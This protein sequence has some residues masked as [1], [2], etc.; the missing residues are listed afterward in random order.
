MNFPEKLKRKITIRE[1]DNALRHLGEMNDLVDF[2]SNDYLGFALSK[3]LNTK[4]YQFLER[5]KVHQNGATGSRL[6]SGN[7]EL[8]KMVEEE[9]SVIHNVE[10]A[11]IFNSGY[12]A[13]LGLL[14]S[15][16]QRSDII[17]FDEFIHASIRD[18]IQLSNAKSYKFKHNNTSDLEKKLTLFLSKDNFTEQEIY[19]ITESVFSMDGDSPDLNV[20]LK[21][22]EKYNAHFIIDEAHSMGVIGEKGLGMVQQLNLEQRIFARILTFGKGLGCHGAVILGSNELKQFLVNYSRPFIYTTGLV[23]HSLAA[24]KTA[25]D[26]LL[27]DKGFTKKKLLHKNIQHRK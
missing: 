15:I 24:I 18:G 16:P 13:N 25:Y 3:D 4:T 5:Y 2:C 11:L 26:F 6:L 23:P 21:I 22:C 1:I 9:L 14:S 19:V 7:H 8:Y 10:S 17:L 20:M 27:S 12:N